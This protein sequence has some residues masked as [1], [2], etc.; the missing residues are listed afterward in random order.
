MT[1]VLYAVIPAIVI[2]VFIATYFNYLMKKHD[3]K[4][5][6]DRS[7]EKE[8]IVLPLQVHAYE[9]LTVLLERITP[10]PLVMR[11][12]TQEM[13]A[14]QLQLALLRAIRDEFEHNVSMQIYVSDV[15][16]SQIV[17][18]RDESASVIQTAAQ[19]VEAGSPSIRMCQ[20]VFE[21]EAQ[22]G[23]KAIRMALVSIK[24]E[25]NQRLS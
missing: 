10:S 4:Y 20:Q 22:R 13:N 21:L 5:T 12:N 25:L 14:A 19:L 7:V 23:N 11:I 15:L 24:Q 9:R 18:A 16:W 1:E 6:E 3:V 8:K 17:A 2:M